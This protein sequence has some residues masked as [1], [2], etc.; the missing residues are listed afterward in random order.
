[1][2]LP[3][4]RIG[5]PTIRKPCRPVD[6][7]VLRN[8]EFPRFL[9]SMVQT[10]RQAQGVGLAANQVGIDLRAIV[11]ECKASGRYPKAPRFPL[12]SYVNPRIV[13]R[14]KEM[15]TDWEGCLSIPGYR[16]RVPRYA[17]ITIEATRPD[18]RPV[19]RRVTGFEARVFQH[20]IDHI[21]G[22]VYVDRMP[23]MRTLVHEDELTRLVRA[24]GRT[25]GKR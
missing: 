12:Q 5:F 15:V 23:D 25:P 14:S 13:K 17:W 24:A 21:N 20:E 9:R 19:R 1:M 11:L 4:V 6:D 3:I 18:G 10:M 16:G 22:F 2:K 7:A 8:V